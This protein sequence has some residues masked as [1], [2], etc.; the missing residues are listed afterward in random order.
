MLTVIRD[1]LGQ[2]LAAC[3]WVPASDDGT[4]ANDGHWVWVNQ[5]EMSAEAGRY[6]LRQ[7]M[8]QIAEQMP[9]ARGAYWYRRKKTGAKIHWYLRSQ[10]TRGGM[11]HATV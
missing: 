1:E 3:E 4:P 10:L 8:T 6:V 11:T 7:V 2:L 5:L 9:T